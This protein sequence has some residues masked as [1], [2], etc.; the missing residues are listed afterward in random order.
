MF[1]NVQ[2]N[3]L[4]CF[5]LI[6]TF[7]VTVFTYL[8]FICIYCVMGGCFS[9]GPGVAKRMGRC[10]NSR[11]VQIV[12][13]LV[14]YGLIV[15]ALVDHNSNMEGK[16]LKAVIE[17]TYQEISDS[18][19][20]SL[21]LGVFGLIYLIHSS[22]SILRWFLS[23]RY[24]Q[25]CF[26]PTELKNFLA[27]VQSTEPHCT[28]Q[29]TR[30]A[31]LCP[32]LATDLTKEFSPHLW[33]EFTESIDVVGARKNRIE[34]A[35]NISDVLEELLRKN[36][37][38]IVDITTEVGPEDDHSLTNT[39]Y[40][41]YKV[42]DSASTKFRKSI[43]A[44]FMVQMPAFN[45]SCVKTPIPCDVDFTKK[46]MHKLTFDSLEEDHSYK[47]LQL[48]KLNGPNLTAIVHREM[49]LPVFWYI[50]WKHKDILM[51]PSVIFPTLGTILAAVF[52]SIVPRH[53][54]DVCMKYSYV[55][56]T[57]APY[58]LDRTSP[59]IDWA[60]EPQ[61]VTIV[62]P[63]SR[64]LVPRDSLSRIVTGEIDWSNAESGARRQLERTVSTESSP[65]ILTPHL[66]RARGP[67]SHNTTYFRRSLSPLPSYHP[68][69]FFPDGME[70][71][72]S[73]TTVFI[74]DTENVTP[75]PDY[76]KIKRVSLGVKI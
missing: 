22:V 41:V 21:I 59:D 27:R 60:E 11:P 20:Y 37:V 34:S 31:Q 57:E 56:Q 38:F 62:M 61:K 2:I 74:A 35:Q 69:I 24:P 13:Q 52:E 30:S 12:L 66:D 67:S 42:M 8:L 6:I 5:I 36:K 17:Q 65:P 63:S 32:E 19:S 75:P 51:I 76:D 29:V 43:N 71:P 47:K 15:N 68:N 14:A 40:F 3:S 54:L 64:F 39:K 48:S 26:S 53:T 50:M 44:S 16:E 45:G 28:I 1:S 46:E 73:Y 58:K 72:P 10:F 25:S 49:D 18:L 23:E 55:P 70:E 33:T 7:T 4:N 9:E